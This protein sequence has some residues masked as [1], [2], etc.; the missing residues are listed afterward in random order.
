[1]PLSTAER[2]AFLA[3]PHIGSLAVA[4]PEK[5]R[6]PLVVPVWYGYRPGGEPWV[7]IFADSVKARLMADTGRFSL[8]AERVTPTVRYVSVEGPIVSTEAT[9]DDEHRTMVERYLPPE[10]AAV[11]LERAAN[12]VGRQITVRMRPEH[13]FSA[14]LGAV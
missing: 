8:L 13:W 6:A 12:E 10:S 14:D 5:D 11:Y 9:T 1:M 3:E 7:L 4:R 2:E